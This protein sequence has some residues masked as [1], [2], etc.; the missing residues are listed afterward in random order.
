MTP[1]SAWSSALSVRS[2]V[3]LPEP[4]GPMTAV[5]VPAGTSNEMPRRT[6]WSPNALWTS[7]R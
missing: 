6:S 5:T 1:A 7:E 2:T 4:D 3:V